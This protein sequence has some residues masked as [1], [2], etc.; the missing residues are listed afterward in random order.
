[1]KSNLRIF[2]N[3][4][5]NFSTCDSVA[6]WSMLPIQMVDLRWLLLLLEAPEEEPDEL[7]VAK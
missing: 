7:I 4:F 2:P 3:G 5:T 6:R 1:M